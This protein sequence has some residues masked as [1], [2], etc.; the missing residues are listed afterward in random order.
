M[1]LLW[2]NQ[3]NSGLYEPGFS[4]EKQTEDFSNT[5]TL[6]VGSEWPE[7]EL[8]QKCA[9]PKILERIWR[10]QLVKL[11]DHQI[12][13]QVGSTIIPHPSWSCHASLSSRPLHGF[14]VQNPSPGSH[15]LQVI[16][17][18][19]VALI[20]MQGFLETLLEQIFFF[21]YLLCSW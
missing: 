13:E 17:S 16:H 11:P 15:L 14:I 10:K 18:L 21:I 9:D 3:T 4:A 1:I 6:A 7:M 2:C 12:S 20:T 5:Q 8:I 19:A